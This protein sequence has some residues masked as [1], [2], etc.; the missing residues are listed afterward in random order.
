MVIYSQHVFAHCLIEKILP[1]TEQHKVPSE[2]VINTP[3]PPKMMILYDKSELVFGGIFGTNK[4]ND[5]LMR[6]EKSNIREINE[7]KGFSDSW[8]TGL[9][10]ICQWWAVN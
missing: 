5:E 2:P 8:S 9:Q 10:N 3:E 6:N 7:V 1:I 4:N